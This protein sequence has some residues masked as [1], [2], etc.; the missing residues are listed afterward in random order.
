M[1]TKTKQLILLDAAIERAYRELSHHA[2][3]SDD[4]VKTLSFV[5][6]LNKIKEENTPKSVSR[7]TLA[8]VF[9]NLAG[10]FM[11]IKHEN[12]NVITSRAL[13]LLMKAR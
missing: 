4:Y 1:F 7:D 6:Q 5:T 11:I 9:A 12:V 2:V 8:V 3:G 10:I 13:N